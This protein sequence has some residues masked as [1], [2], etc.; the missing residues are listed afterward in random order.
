M[1]GFLGIL[2]LDWMFQRQGLAPEW[3]MSLR[4]VLTAV[5]LLSLLT[6]VI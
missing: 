2:G 4:L 1:A 6:V 3:W 5:V